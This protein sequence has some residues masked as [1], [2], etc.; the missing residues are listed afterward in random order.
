MMPTSERTSLSSISALYLSAGRFDSKTRARFSSDFHRCY[1]SARLDDRIQVANLICKSNHIPLDVLALLCCDDD[2]VAMPILAHSPL[3]GEG[4]L[5]TQILQ[6]SAADREAIAH[7][8]DLTP[9][10]ISHLLFF[11]EVT[12][13]QRLCHNMAY[14]SGISDALKQ[15][16]AR[17]SG[18][19]S[20]LT[21]QQAMT[22]KKNQ[23]FENLVSS[24]E[25]SWSE[26]YQPNSYATTPV[27][28]APMVDAA[29][30]DMS[31]EQ[32]T[33]APSVICDFDD[34]EE[35]LTAG[36][37]DEQQS[38]LSAYQ[39]P[40]GDLSESS[41]PDAD[42]D[43]LQSRLEA[44]FEE[45]KDDQMNPYPIAPPNNEI[46]VETVDQTGRLAG[47]PE[48]GS[49]DFL[50]DT[51]LALLEK[52]GGSDWEMLD[53]DAIEALA[54]SL[55]KQDLTKAE[56]DA[57]ATNAVD[58]SSIND[59]A[60]TSMAKTLSKDDL[61]QVENDAVDAGEI[62]W[63][64]LDDEAIEALAGSLADEDLVRMEADSM[65]AAGGPDGR[66]GF[67][68]GVFDK[69]N[70]PIPPL[71]V[72]DAVLRPATISFR[73]PDGVDEEAP[74]DP[75]ISSQDTSDNLETKAK[76]AATSVSATKPITDSVPAFAGSTEA[77][78]SVSGDVSTAPAQ[79]E[80]SKAPA[81]TRS[82]VATNEQEKR[83]PQITLTIRKQT[84]AERDAQADALL[85]SAT[86]KVELSS[87][88]EQDWL[89]ALDKLNRD[90]DSDSANRATVGF[91]ETAQAAAPVP[92]IRVEDLV[93]PI[94]TPT[95]AADK[96]V[97][98]SEAKEKRARIESRP[99][100][101]DIIAELQM[102]DQPLV[103]PV[104]RSPGNMGFAP[105]VMSLDDLDLVEA[106]PN[107][108]SASELMLG[109]SHS[110]VP[111]VDLV[112]PIDITIHENGH[113]Y[114][115]SDVE[116]TPMRVVLEQL[117]KEKAA[118]TAPAKDTVI[119]TPSVPDA[120][121]DMTTL[122]QM[123]AHRV[124]DV[125]EYESLKAAETVAVAK[126][127]SRSPLST[128]PQEAE[129]TSPVLRAPHLRE[130]Q[131]V[132]P[133]ED[134]MSERFFELDEETRLALL[135]G[136]MAQTLPEAA[137]MAQD[138]NQRRL[139]DEDTAQDLVMARFSNDRLKLTE[140]L[141][142]LSGHS[143]VQMSKL[144]QDTGG[145][146]LVCFLY[147][148]GLDE[149]STLS[150]VLHGPDAVSHSYEKVA[151]LMTLYHQLYPAAAARI[152][153]DLFGDVKKPGFVHQT[154]HDDG[155]GAASPRQ[156]GFAGGQQNHPNA[157]QA[158]IF[159]RRVPDADRA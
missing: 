110:A 120:P 103:Q 88:T 104:K 150:M 66:M 23:S 132:T 52:L 26:H 128:A 142:T 57:I 21:G 135:Q 60:I 73:T 129:A 44:L 146:S 64:T 145:E 101:P 149:G 70:A 35:A 126:P 121:D 38:E 33:D 47:A 86:K 112:E 80:V 5:T 133:P 100:H 10:L 3:L 118:L 97:V 134:G 125:E 27:A 17:I 42:P 36:A 139:I 37:Q 78:L 81:S 85:A 6:G 147:H 11:G 113:T 131:G 18:I 62:D 123:A 83:K 50:N 49:D 151:Q 20:S 7:R 46:D 143:R 93:A 119:T 87:I 53:D 55:A 117:A 89:T 28:D 137:M 111:Y 152:V 69:T 114:A 16:I 61:E 141:H 90:Y 94:V 48:A 75:T 76:E 148:I 40:A 115:L 43:P 140:M 158:P 138:R 59:D 108:P 95:P 8:H 31:D 2:R 92:T 84:S 91:V 72:K 71:E 107:L 156:R 74:E 124:V 58:W 65:A 153:R 127:E 98:A 22:N 4:E 116:N 29:S 105:K 82:S 9:V 122:P 102:D 144:L 39:D 34:P 109:Q 159:G 30:K 68:I 99:L 130:I 32:P 154:V 24:M 54:S 19:D 12:V 25:Q 56:N 136:V 157:A 96:T 13:A 79:P 51:D 106:N 14:L 15:R 41:I 67:T 63:S 45:T 1:N 155:K 77:P